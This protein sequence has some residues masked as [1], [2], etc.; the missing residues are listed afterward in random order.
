[1]TNT[2]KP[3]PAP[4]DKLNRP[5]NNLR[6]SVTDRCN[7]R[8][9]YCMPAD[10]FGRDH[11]FLNKDQLLSFEEIETLVRAF[12]LLGVS[13][14]R[15]TG[16]EP[17]LRKD[18][19]ILVARLAGL[20]GLHELT[21]TTN[22][23]RLSAT[24]AAA[25]KNAGITRVNISLDALDARINQKINKIVT[26]LADV[27]QGIDNALNAGFAAV[28]INMVVQ[29][30]INDGEIIPMVQHFRGSGAILRFIEFMDVG[31]YN[32][33]SLDQVFTAAQIIERINAQYPLQPL[34]QNYR[35]EVAQRWRYQDGGGE[36][37]VIA[38]VSQPFCDACSRARLSAQGELFTCLFASDGFNLRDLLPNAKSPQE[39]AA[40]IASIWSNRYDQYSALRAQL[41]V[42][43]SLPKIEMSYIGG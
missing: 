17:L 32:R 27:L 10:V 37:G 18:L 3:T 4:T 12:I 33:W 19:E 34:Q 28:K 6:V 1:M 39:L 38:S 13:K 36:I 20:D 16:G 5:L 2:I 42:A 21:L 9:E 35:G 15:L 29:K 40:H 43:T 24:R 31:N 41:R 22:A 7:F 11:R 26:P 23:S 8:C 14:V 25:L 30:D